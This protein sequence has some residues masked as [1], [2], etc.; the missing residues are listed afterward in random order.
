VEDRKR[1]VA[2]AIRLEDEEKQRRILESEIE[3]ERARRE[4]EA[5]RRA[6]QM[7]ADAAM[8]EERATRIA[9]TPQKLSSTSPLVKALPIKV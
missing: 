3:S 9:N 8:E 2:L 1:N 6:N 5:D 4:S 7:K